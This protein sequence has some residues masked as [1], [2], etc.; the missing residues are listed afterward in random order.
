MSHAR[1]RLR[2]HR[3]NHGIYRLLMLLSVT[4]RRAA[5]GFVEGHPFRWLAPALL[6]LGLLLPVSAQGQQLDPPS[7]TVYD[8]SIEV[9]TSQTQT[10]LDVGCIE[11]VQDTATAAGN[12]TWTSPSSGDVVGNSHTLTDLTENTQYWV[13]LGVAR[14]TDAGCVPSN[15]SST[16]IGGKTRFTPPEIAV[17]EITP[18]SAKVSWTGE[19]QHSYYRL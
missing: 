15:L 17:S 2:G 11:W 9:N 16:A 6:A 14:E 8:T 19:A 7:L 3:G 10:D 1:E 13:R 4:V 18:V 5:T 12:V